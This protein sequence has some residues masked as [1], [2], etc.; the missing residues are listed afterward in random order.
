MAPETRQVHATAEEPMLAFVRSL[1]GRM[2]WVPRTLV[3]AALMFHSFD[4]FQHLEAFAAMMDI[5][6]ALAFLGAYLEAAAA[7]L[8][9]AGG[10]ASPLA[11]PLTRLG[12]LLLVPVMIGAIAV[13]HWP[14]WSFVPD[15]DAGFPMGGMEY[16]VTLI[17]VGLYFALRGNPSA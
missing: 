16:P 5:P 15:A 4:H 3:A 7:L 14:G 1:P 11:D 10:F 9:L 12:G 8:L 17:A 13:A 6:Q 2:H